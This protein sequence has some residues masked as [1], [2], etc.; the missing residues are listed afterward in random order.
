MEL[1]IDIPKLWEM[2]QSYVL[3][4]GLKFIAALAIFV[5]GRW[6]AKAITSMVRRALDAAE[7]DQTLIRFLGSLLYAILLTLVILAAIGQLGI[8]TSGFVA[9]L[10][11][12]GLAIGLALQGSLSNFAAGVLIILFRP[13]RV[14]DFI[15]A[16][17]VSGSIE[18]VQIFTTVLKTGDNK[19]VIIPNSEV[20]AGV[21]TNYSAH[22]TRRV[23]MV[24]GCGYE[25]DLAQVKSVLKDILD[26]DERVLADPAPT[27]GLLELADSSVNFAVRPWVKTGDYW[28]VYFDVNEKVK[29]RFDE[30]GLSIPYPQSDVHLYKHES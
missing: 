26:S 3:D 6:I 1:S 8:K 23:D 16:A 24:F 19:Q 9:I 22:D 2:T 21:I 20:M 18:A 14:G 17:G 30:A 27:I 10:G 25:D 15:E 28:G 5:I 13:Y 4:F 7:T 11:A 29:M 12:A